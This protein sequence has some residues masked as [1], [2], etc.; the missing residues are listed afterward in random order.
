[1]AILIEKQKQQRTLVFALVFILFVTAG[2]IYWNKSKTSQVISP[3]TVRS[4]LFVPKIV[5]PLDI[6][7]GLFK[8]G[9]FL[10]LG[11][12]EPIPIPSS[13]GKRNPFLP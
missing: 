7:H 9:A 4:E 1:M 8:D 5:L 11:S 12:Y 10:N 6:P 3:E 2:L 13:E